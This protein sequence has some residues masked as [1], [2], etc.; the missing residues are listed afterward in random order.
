MK[1]KFLGLLTVMAIVFT[2]VLAGCAPSK[3]NQS[4]E[5]EVKREIDELVLSI[6]GEP[7]TG[8]DPTTGWGRYGSPLCQST[9]LKRDHNLNSYL[10]ADEMT[11]MLDAITQAQIWNAILKIAEQRKMGMVVVSHDMNLIQQLCHRVIEIDHLNT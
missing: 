9:L 4:I 10:I 2:L 3:S 6:K 1:K 11:T 5:K 7:D 8:F